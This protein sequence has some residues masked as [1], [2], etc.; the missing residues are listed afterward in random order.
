MLDIVHAETT[1]IQKQGK[2]QAFKKL[3]EGSQW[4][5][6]GMWFA[7][8]F[9]AMI[10]GFTVSPESGYQCARMLIVAGYGYVGVIMVLGMISPYYWNPTVF[11]IAKDVVLFSTELVMTVYFL[12]LLSVKRMQSELFI[13]VSILFIIYG[14]QAFT[15]VQY[16]NANFKA[17]HI[18]RQFAVDNEW[19]SKNFSKS[20]MSSRVVY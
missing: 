6:I 20:S 18:E 13:Y 5:R 12:V 16:F 17:C 11:K 9:F 15:V 7:N 4:F 14:Y 2:T 8:L 10:I 19:N 1:A 3:L